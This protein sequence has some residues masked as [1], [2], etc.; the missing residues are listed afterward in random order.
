MTE[1]SGDFQNTFRPVGEQLEQHPESLG[2]FVWNTS[3]LACVWKCTLEKVQ[4]GAACLENCMD[5]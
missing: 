2:Q 1:M 3:E 5:L 4:C